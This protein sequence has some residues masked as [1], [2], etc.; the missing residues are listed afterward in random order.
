[1]EGVDGWLEGAGLLG[2]PNPKSCLSEA[3]GSELDDGIWLRIKG[4]GEWVE[5]WLV[6]FDADNKGER[7]IDGG[8]DGATVK[9]ESRSNIVGWAFAEG[10]RAE[11]LDAWS[12]PSGGMEVDPST[13]LSSEGED[14]WA[15]S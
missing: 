1:M 10:T 5:I 11:E 6:V 9:R 14:W 12:S 4:D 2:V 13:V 3:E 15:S 7:F 8:V